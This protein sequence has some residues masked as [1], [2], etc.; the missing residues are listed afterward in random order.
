LGHA[1]DFK[2][3]GRAKFIGRVAAIPAGIIGAG[4]LL[5]DDKTRKYAPAA[6]AAGFAPTL[7]QE[8]KAS[9]LATKYVKETEGRRAAKRVAK[10]LLRAFG[11]YLALPVGAALGVYTA[12]KLLDRSKK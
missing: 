3:F 12:G 5:K 1:A 7:W 2:T 4:A 6:T 11:T 9:I 10:P 8:G